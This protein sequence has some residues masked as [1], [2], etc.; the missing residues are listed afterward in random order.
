MKMRDLTGSS[1]GNILEWFDF[2]L[3]IYLA[4]LL[5][6]HFFPAA[7]TQ[8]TA[9]EAL[10]VFAAGFICRPLG[11]I[12]F[13]FLGDRFGRVLSLRLSILMITITMI[14]VGCLPSFATWGITATILFTL[15]RV[16]QGL[17]VGGEY[18]AIMI[19]LAESAPDH[20]RGFFTSFAAVAANLGFLLASLSVL[21]LNKNFS[22]IHIESWAWRIPF[23]FA[24]AIGLLLFINRLRLIETPVFQALLKRKKIS[25]WPLIV[26][27]IKAPRQLLQILGLSCMGGVFYYVFFGYMPTFLSEN[28]G[29]PL[30]QALTVQSIFLII[31]I[32]MVPFAGIIGDR[33]GRR[34]LLIITAAG[35]ILT[36]LPSFYLL[37]IHSYFLLIL[38][39]AVATLLSSIEQGNTLIAVVENCPADVRASG[40]SFTYNVGMA[41]FGGTA[42]LIV[43]TLTSQINSYAPAYYL[44]AAAAL[45][46][47][48]VLGLSET[49][50]KSMLRTTQEGV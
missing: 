30:S 42:P 43:A 11:G 32:F 12:F 49:H 6:R 27:F 3:Y 8:T 15:L 14:L 40:V 17:S 22:E 20:R 21:L 47:I 45:T 37:H 46:L 19:Y 26:A 39:F 50:R 36:A 9:F 34:K 18:A 4:P 10:A 13:G 48:V 1:L 23:L 5:G 16:C 29:I 24:G 31:M 2:G 35:I 33:F 25:T 44:I 38:V 7:S 28:I 41:L